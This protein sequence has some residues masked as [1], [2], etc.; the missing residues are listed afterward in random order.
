MST[1]GWPG[2]RRSRRSSRRRSAR[3]HRWPR[4]RAAAGWSPGS[5][6]STV[7][8]R[9]RQASTLRP[10]ARPA[11]RSPGPAPPARSRSGADQPD[12]AGG[13]AGGR[14]DPGRQQLGQ[15]VRRVRGHLLAAHLLRAVRTSTYRR[16]T[17]GGGLT[18]RRS[19]GVPVAQHRAGPGRAGSARSGREAPRARCASP[20]RAAKTDPERQAGPQR[21]A[22]G[23][24]TPR[25]SV[26]SGGCVCGCRWPRSTAGP[27]RRTPAS[28]SVPGRNVVCVT[29]P[30]RRFTGLTATG[31]VQRTAPV[32]ASITVL[33]RDGRTSSRNPP[34]RAAVA[35]P[36]LRGAAPALQSR[37][38]GAIRQAVVTR[39]R[40]PESI[41]V[42]RVRRRAGSR[43]P[44]RDAA[45]RR[46][47]ARAR[48]RPAPRRRGRA[49]SRT[50]RSRPARR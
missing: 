35:D 33:P 43:R 40:R 9:A 37:R 6:C 11:A 13:V 4:R 23:K 26:R 1:S 41:R 44:G 3:S 27:A 16:M 7:V 45:P 38:G 30:I 48:R 18:R 49:A 22:G 2:G 19:A 20:V 34:V 17:L 8:A 15:G 5:R 10:P 28:Y 47:A 42:D 46:R 21:P 32:R 25:S 24:S 29:T 50:A 39:A 31:E 14:A 12:A 36:P